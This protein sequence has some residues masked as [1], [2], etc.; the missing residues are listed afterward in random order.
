MS[1]GL[2]ASLDTAP[3]TL[4]SDSVTVVSQTHLTHMWGLL[5]TQRACDFF[6]NCIGL[7]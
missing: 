2:Y 5:V 6:S 7:R 3:L 1:G 4:M